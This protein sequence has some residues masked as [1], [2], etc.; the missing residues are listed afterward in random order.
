MQTSTATI[1]NAENKVVALTLLHKEKN[2]KGQRKGRLHWIIVPMVVKTEQRL[3]FWWQKTNRVEA[4]RLAERQT[5]VM[6]SMASVAPF[7]LN[8][9][10]NH[11]ASFFFPSSST[12]SLSRSTSST[13]L[14]LPQ[15]RLFSPLTLP[16][17]LS[18][19]LIRTQLLPSA[20]KKSNHD[21]H[22]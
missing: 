13:F 4:S 2:E 10:P 9:T 7:S 18:F 14:L 15:Q 21:I 16:R 12:P 5:L 3:T 19:H 20:K 1:R 6:D 17:A 22:K 11:L 8:N